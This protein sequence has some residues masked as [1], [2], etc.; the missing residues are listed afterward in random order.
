MSYRLTE[1]VK[2]LRV[3]SELLKNPIEQRRSDLTPTMDR[4]RSRATIFVPPT[5]MTSGLPCSFESELRR[6]S[7]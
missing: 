6:Y 4:N 3:D 1:A 7:L 5:L 2:G